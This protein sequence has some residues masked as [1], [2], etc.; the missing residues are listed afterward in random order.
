[1]FFGQRENRNRFLIVSQFVLLVFAAVQIV[2]VSASDA[3]WLGKPIQ[4]WDR[5]DLERIFTDSPWA[6]AATVTRTWLPISEKDVHDKPLSGSG[7]KLP[8]EVERANEGTYGG[9]LNVNVYWAS[10]RV[11]RAASARKSELFDGKQGVDAAKYAN[12]PQ[13]EYQIV[14]QSADMAPFFRHDEAYFRSIAYLQ[15]KK[16][17]L[18]L[19]PSRVHYERDTQ[20]VLV[21][22]AIFFFPKRTAAGEP[23][24]SADEKGVAF[25]CKFEGSTLQVNFEPQK[26]VDSSGPDL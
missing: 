5:K 20:G 12:E 14:V 6:R 21:T 8:S 19:S 4:Q 25:N 3:P 24:I 18:K 1:M 22:A 2:C 23:N 11:M 15:A 10:S 26:M 17:K 16:T 7:R 13:A 9:D